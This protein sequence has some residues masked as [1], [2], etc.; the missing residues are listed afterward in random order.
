MGTGFLFGATKRF[1]NRT[2]VM[3]TKKHK[4]VHFTW[5]N[6]TIYKLCFSKA[7]L[8]NNGI[9]N[10]IW[11]FPGRPRSSLHGN[12]ALLRGR[13]LPFARVLTVTVVLHP[14]GFPH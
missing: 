11:G 10:L 4:I 2:V 8:K 5:E 12:H 6:F 7:I 14:A 3:V 9:K 13:A 1:Y